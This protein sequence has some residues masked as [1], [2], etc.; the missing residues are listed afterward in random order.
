MV[1][2]CWEW[3]NL[4]VQM[5]WGQSPQDCVGDHI[6]MRKWDKSREGCLNSEWMFRACLL[7]ALSMTQYLRNQTPLLG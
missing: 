7:A 6:Q 4:D 3:W 1:E 2:P 5:R